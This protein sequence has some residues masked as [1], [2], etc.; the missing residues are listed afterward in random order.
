MTTLVQYIYPHRR[1]CNVFQIAWFLKN[2]LV[3]TVHVHVLPFIRIVTKMNEEEERGTLE[4]FVYS[5]ILELLLNETEDEKDIV[6]T[7]N[8]KSHAFLCNF[9]GNLHS[10]QA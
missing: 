4:N 5:S 7:I 10:E 2:A 8:R 1:E 3:L 6:H 9:G